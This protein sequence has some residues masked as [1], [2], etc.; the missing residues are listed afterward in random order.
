MNDKK[1]L[2]TLIKIAKNQQ[3]IIQKLAQTA[4]GQ[5]GITGEHHVGALCDNK[6]VTLAAKPMIDAL[7]RQVPDGQKFSLR[8]ASL[9]EGGVLDITL[10]VAMKDLGSPAFRAV[11]QYLSRGLI[12]E[13]IP[14]SDVSISRVTVIG[15]TP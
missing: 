14:G 9:S 2:S 8:T 4:P 5:V 6:D 12:G 10:W 7:I 3:K 1:I 11:S 15:E 13:Q